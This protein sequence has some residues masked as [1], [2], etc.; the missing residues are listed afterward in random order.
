M[1]PSLV[2]KEVEEGEGRPSLW[3]ALGGVLLPPGV[4]FPLLPSWSRRVRKEERGRRK[5]GAA[6]PSLVQ[7]GPKGEGARGL[8]WLALSLSTKAHVA[9]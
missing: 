5:G 1:P 9:Q 7:F 8:P 6:P 2:Y 3:R 4:G